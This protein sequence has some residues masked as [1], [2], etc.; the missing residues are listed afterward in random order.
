MYR[1]CGVA[2]LAAIV[3]VACR[4]SDVLT[5]PAPA[6]VLGSAALQN[7][8]GAEGAFNAAKAQLFSAAD[9]SF[10]LVMLS[11]LLTD[12]FTASGF[13]YFAAS[14]ANIDA[15]LTAGT[16]GFREEGD[17][18][19][20]LLLQARS[21]LLRVVPGLMRYE[22][23]S[24]QSKVGE[25]DALAGYAEL[26]LAE[27]YCAGTPLSDVVPGG[28]IR[29]G[30][31][32]TTDSL[33]GVAEAHFDSAIARAHGDSTVSGLASVGLGRVR[34]DRG[35]YGPAATAVAGVATSM[36]YN[37]ELE[38]TDALGA[39]HTPNLYAYGV[40]LG[41]DR[42]FNVADDE[43]GNGLNFR[44]AHDPRLAFDSSM[45]TTDGGTWYLP[46]K[47]EVNLSAIPLATGIEARLI[48]AEAA[49]NA[50]QTGPWLADLNAL[51][52]SGCTVAGPDTT[53]VIGTG[54]VPGQTTGLPS[55]SDPGT[56][57]GRV[58][59]TFRERAFWLFGTGGRLGDLRR[60]I[61]QYGRDQSTVFPTGPYANGNNPQLPAPIPNY[62][63]DVN[64]TLPTPAGLS[65]SGQAI[66]NPNYKGCLTSS[67]TA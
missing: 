41:F 63:A 1:R 33:L 53:C 22:P 4:P 28:T 66:T 47:F 12:E 50:G 26:L 45:T 3:A 36:V 24:G 51:R 49:L 60:L 52:N 19:W 10:R 11:G 8:N 61:R 16:T 23:A 15:R 18:A 44:S 38:P 29:Y 43:G 34:L 42:S 65:T 21:S 67:K 39:L 64:L 5:V 57:S 35:H 37:A 59:L 46:A 2:T 13:R 27:S 7:Q 62:G 31:P 6:E 54:Q 32:L 48:E 25:A 9:G 58:S 20:P 17:V 55:L 30:M 14:E 56:D 40:E